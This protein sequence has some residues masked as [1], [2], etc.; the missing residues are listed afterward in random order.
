[1][2]KIRNEKRR[3]EVNAHN[4][5]VIDFFSGTGGSFLL[6]TPADN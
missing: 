1:M 4:S 2:E 6:F 3:Q 5:I